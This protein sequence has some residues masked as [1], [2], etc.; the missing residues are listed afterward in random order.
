MLNFKHFVIM[1]LATWIR[2]ISARLK[3]FE[4]KEDTT[5]C[6]KPYSYENELL[7]IKYEQLKGINQKFNDL[8]ERSAHDIAEDEALCDKVYKTEAQILAIIATYTTI[9][10]KSNHDCSPT[11]TKQGH[12]IIKLERIEIPKF[13][14]NYM[15][16]L[17]FKDTFTALVDANQQL[18]NIEKFIHLKNSL[19][20]TASSILD[21]FQVSSD[22]YSAAFDLLKQRYENRGLILKAHLDQIFALKI[23]HKNYKDL[24]YFCD[25]LVANISAIKSLEIDV[26][27]WDR[28]LIHHFVKEFTCEMIA[29]WERLDSSSLTDLIAFVNEKAHH[30]ELS[31]HHSRQPLKPQP[32]RVLV[33]TGYSCLYCHES[34]RLTK[35]SSFTQLNVSERSKFVYQN[36]LCRMCLRKGHFTKECFSKDTCIHCKRRHHTALH[37]ETQPKVA[38]TVTNGTN[39]CLLTTAMVYVLNK[40]GDR[41]QARAIL[42]NGS[43][44]NFICES[45]ATQLALPKNKLNVPIQGIH[46][47][48]AN[49]ADSINLKLC[50][51]VNNFKLGA[52]CLILNSITSE[53][54]QTCFRTDV[55]FP[56][57]LL[58]DPRFS[59]SAPVSLLLGAD[60]F[61]QI[62]L[63]HRKSITKG[64]IKYF[65]SQLGYLATGHTPLQSPLITTML[66]TIKGSAQ[67]GSVTGS[68]GTATLT[69]AIERFWELESPSNINSP[70]SLEEQAFENLFM[71]TTTRDETGRFQVRLGLKDDPVILGNSYTR[72]LKCLISLEKRLLSN[73]TLSKSYHDFIDEYI[74]LGHMSLY[75]GTS[76]TITPFYFPHHAVV[77]ESSTTTKLRVVFNGSSKTSSG[78]SLNDILMVGPVVQ[79]D[80]FSILLRFRTHKW[81]LTADV[82][83]MYRQIRIAPED[84]PV[85]RL[86][87]RNQTTKMVEEYQLNT[88][89]Y[90]T[91]SAPFL[92]T[93]CMT[94]LAHLNQDIYPLASSL[95]K[96]DMYVDDLLTGH[97]DRSMLLTVKEQLN[98]MFKEVGMSL[99]K[100]TTN[101]PSL[102]CQ[103]DDKI[104]L[105]DPACSTTLGL[106][107]LSQ[108]DIF[109]F[110]LHINPGEL[111]T[112]RSIL[113]A[114]SKIFD[115]IGLLAPITITS[116]LFMQRL[117]QESL[118]WDDPISSSTRDEWIRFTQQFNVA[119][120]IQIKRHTLGDTPNPI[121]TLHGF[122]DASE[123]AYGACIYLVS[124]D[125]HTQGWNSSLLCAKSKV[126]P[127]KQ[128][129]LPRLEL[130]AALLL[131]HLYKKVRN[132][133]SLIVKESFLWTDSTIALA[134]ISDQPY[135]WTQFVA[136]RVSD[137]QQNSESATWHHVRSKDN[138]ADLISRGL[139][140]TELASSQLWWKGPHWITQPPLSW[141]G[142]GTAPLAVIPELRT[143][144]KVFIVT[145]VFMTDDLL[146]RFSTFSKLVRV[147][148]LLRRFITKCRGHLTPQEIESAKI[149]VIRI[150]QYSS[151]M[152][153]IHNL[154]TNRPLP[155]ES[156]LNNLN[157][158]LDKNQLLRAG[159]RL[160]NSQIPE[161]HRH[162][163]I[164]N[165]KSPLSRLIIIHYHRKMLHTGTQSLLAFIRWKYW[166]I[167]AK[168]L[169][170]QVLSKCT[171]C[172]KYNPKPIQQLMGHLPSERVNP[173]R[174]FSTVGVDY[175]GPFLSRD[176]NPKSKINYKIYIAVFVCFATK[177][178]HL[179]LVSDLT[180]DAFLN[181]FKRFIARRGKC[182]HLYSDNGTNFVGAKN[183]L[184]SFQQQLISQFPQ[185]Q[186]WAVTEGITWQFIPPRSPHHGGLW[187]SAVK[188]MKN[189]LIKTIGKHILTFEE[190]YTVLTQVEAC[191]NSRPISPLSNDPN[192]L[193]PLTPGHFLIGSPLLTTAE[194][195]LTDLPTNTLNRYQLLT[196]LLQGFWKRWANEYLN[197]LQ[198]RTKWFRAHQAPVQVGDLVILK[199]DLLHPLKWKL[200]RVSQ[201]HTGADGL[202][203]VVSV[204][205]ESGITTRSVQ[206][207][208]RVPLE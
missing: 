193:L 6:S 145:N 110:K 78:I 201:L 9:L 77:K 3:G 167:S 56:K 208:C 156:K 147:T 2:T 168:V 90:G 60:I 79:Q 94:H 164:L 21:Q 132:T 128:V 70:L 105:G 200:G 11:T 38:L 177:A 124:Y 101:I 116:K 23:N 135:R 18:T 67:G 122:S 185:V 181:C 84:K 73:P 118:K 142:Q 112:K 198:V 136:N 98:Q 61:W 121:I 85:Q 196:Q 97:N 45:L 157:V 114:I 19:T 20:G 115:P 184:K 127:L 126:A 195:Q 144:K 171:L 50:S 139:N 68:R 203:R 138:P 57:R 89:T 53:T 99:R 87:W 10:N 88:V 16:W 4:I 162:P 175:A 131:S 43:Q 42:D 49:I 7:K 17:Q 188:S 35:C 47:Q 41:I 161:Q 197:S 205:T 44:A 186:A 59:T 80:L 96:N 182:S 52:S 143:M 13:N 22:N 103:R 158:F 137:I 140:P 100:W 129:S 66:T 24:K 32:K 151:F 192:D 93:R 150:S 125:P 86:L 152:P 163:Y 69:K 174:P 102:P 65:A 204:K 206:K 75:D 74:R 14:G 81:V 154:Q 180:S 63:P 153:E 91:A 76:C 169:V 27:N 33:A 1:S 194:P 15:N 83:K 148:A 108:S 51:H 71:S 179:E 104:T 183:E 160:Q 134:W 187:E 202:I 130:C 34:H 30:M 92:A 123:K 207:L 8:Y 26:F 64:S 31:A 40:H 48:T 165:P 95:I 191:L 12:P 62:L 133:I 199:E 5:T 106:Q 109:V 117:W 155:K 54:P 82:E 107:W 55:P 178:V 37:D 25:A 159:G 172:F 119:S 29:E 111:I 173:S 149:T 141:P 190:F 166:I 39:L 113:S 58:A 170:K 46:H 176:R 36:K 146:T 120:T 72:A 28:L 189:L